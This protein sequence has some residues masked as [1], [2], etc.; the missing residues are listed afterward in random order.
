MNKPQFREMFDYNPR[1]GDIRYNEGNDRIEYYSRASYGWKPL[2]QEDFM[3][4]QYHIH[5][6]QPDMPGY[7]DKLGRHI[8]VEDIIDTV[9]ILLME[10]GIVKDLEHFRRLLNNKMN[11]KKLADQLEA[12]D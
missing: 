8:R 12:M 9:L 1:Y 7:C 10:Q 3:P 6:D 11:A 2:K 4:T 5:K